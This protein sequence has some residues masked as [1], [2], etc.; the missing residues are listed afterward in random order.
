MAIEG[1]TA[2]FE[3]AKDGESMIIDGGGLNEG[4]SITTGVRAP[5]CVG[6]LSRTVPEIGASSRGVDVVD[7]EASAGL[8]ETGVEGNISVAIGKSPEGSF[9]DDLSTTVNGVS[10]MEDGEGERARW[11]GSNRRFPRLS[12]TFKATGV[13]GSTV[14]EGLSSAVCSA[15]WEAP[16]R[17][18]LNLE[19][20]LLATG[21]GREKTSCSNV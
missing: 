4:E 20:L 21:C 9:G 19:V 16:P 7:R 17:L 13:G 15:G 8:R 18:I 2:P 6:V 14:K 3:G 12:V 10:G 5:D 1:N 11:V